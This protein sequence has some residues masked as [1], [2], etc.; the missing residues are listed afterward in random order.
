MEMKLPL[1]LKV[2]F[3]NN[4]NNV[5]WIVYEQTPNVKKKIWNQIKNYFIKVVFKSTFVSSFYKLDL[6]LIN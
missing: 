4:T 5:I 1:G 3:K 2:V 6:F